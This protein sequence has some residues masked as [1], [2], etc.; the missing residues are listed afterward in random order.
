MLMKQRSRSTRR[1]PHSG[2]QDD[3]LSAAM[4]LNHPILAPA[5]IDRAAQMEI[6]QRTLDAVRQGSGQCILLA[7]EAGIGKT[8]LVAEAKT[9]AD[10]LRAIILQ[11]YCFESDRML[12]FAPLI[13]L[14]R[15]F[16]ARRS[17]D[18]LAHVFDPATPELA[19]LLPELSSLLPGV[20]PTP[21]LEPK[22]EKWRLFTALAHVLTALDTL[23]VTS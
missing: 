18:T 22:Q 11:G 3:Q 10:R 5:L 12:P 15:T 4:P 20:A 23:P 16:C 21:P 6:L 7:G 1:N 13:D 14:L 2:M 17:L 19:K 8:R 9:Y